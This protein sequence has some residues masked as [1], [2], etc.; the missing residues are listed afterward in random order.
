MKN[1]FRYWPQVKPPSDLRPGRKS[2]FCPFS[3]KK[4]R[5]IV[6]IHFSQKRAENISNSALLERCKKKLVGKKVGQ[7]KIWSEKSWFENRHHS[8][9]IMMIYPQKVS[10]YPPKLIITNNNAIA[11]Y[12]PG[13]SLCDSIEK[14]RSWGFLE[15]WP[16]NHWTGWVWRTKNISTWSASWHWN[17]ITNNNK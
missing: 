9:Q 1:I 7:K 16:N 12:C 6:V 15:V 10:T 11:G 8:T 17:R 13:Q 2:I 3:R 5:K 4:G 14:G